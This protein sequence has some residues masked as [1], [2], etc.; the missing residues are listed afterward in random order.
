MNLRRILI[1]ILV[2]IVI[3]G[4]A[5]YLGRRSGSGNGP[6][7]EPKNEAETVKPRLAAN[8]YSMTQDAQRNI[9]LTTAV[10]Q[11]EEI[12]KTLRV[13]GTVGP[14]EG[15]VAHVF[16]LAQGV[17]R[18]IFVQLGS[19]VRTGQSLLRF[20]NVELGT[21]TGEHRS[22]L[23]SLERA[24][25]Q[26][27][28]SAKNLARAENLLKVE[29][30]SQREY[31]VRRAE[32]EQA[33]AG[34]NS[35]RSELAASEEKLHRFGLTE[36]QIHSISTGSTHRTSS[37]NDVRAPITGVISKYEV[38]QGELIGP[39]KEIFTV[40]D[41]S[42]VWVLADIYEKDLGTVPQRGMCSVR[43]AAFP[44]ETFRGKVEYISESLDPQSRTAKL[45]CVL[46]NQDN[47]IRLDMFAE[48]EIPTTRREMTL[49]VP[50][51]AVQE[52]DNE[53]V[54]FVQS[55]P[56]DFEKRNVKIGS[57]GDQN[58]EILAGV[59]PGERVVTNG[60]L[61]LKFEA[62]RGTLGDD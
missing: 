58:T 2:G 47:R 29:A 30:I 36:D 13:T 11:Q 22:L 48:L 27:D 33:D 43:L 14:E 44:K 34:V 24:Q 42:I 4:A 12:T 26:Q 5:F 7:D 52:I 59:K 15:R 38:A 35:A 10:A 1:L 37:L 46:P 28:V 20:D 21:L 41:P 45:R 9:H 57:K 8:H 49:T 32:K 18:N 53:P 23:G 62:M 31:E 60:T 51:T 16:P 17:V 6:K 3:I 50:N 39:D 56:E 19:Q 40:V 61:Q 55:G 54:V 25:A